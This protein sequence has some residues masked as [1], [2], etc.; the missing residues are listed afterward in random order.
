MSSFP[1][2]FLPDA[3]C[4]QR[5]DLVRRTY[6]SIGSLL[7]AATVLSELDFAEIVCPRRAK[8][9]WWD[10]NCKAQAN[11]GRYK[12]KRRSA[13]ILDTIK[14]LVKHEQIKAK[15]HDNIANRKVPIPQTKKNATCWGDIFPKRKNTKLCKRVP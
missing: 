5:I 1:F 10:G 15:M 7:L 11:G 4:K 3:A 9:N 14:F 12:K 2:S 6:V 8:N 13:N